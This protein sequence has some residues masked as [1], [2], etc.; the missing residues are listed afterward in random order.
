MLGSIAPKAWLARFRDARRST[1][2]PV[3]QSGASGAGVGGRLVSLPA[4][5]SVDGLRPFASEILR[6]VEACLEHRFDLLGSG[7]VRM[8]HGIVC[9]GRA[10]H[11][12]APAAAV[13]ADREGNWLAGRINRSNLGEAR[14][15][16]TLV[17]PDYVPVDWHLDFISGYRW[18]E[19]VWCRDIRYGRLTG[20]D[21]KIPWELSRMQHLPLLAGAHALARSGHSGFRPPAVYINEFR[22]Q[23]L[24]F[25]AAN[26][27]R[28]GVNWHCPMDVGIRVV[29]ILAAYDLFRG[30][31][32]GWD[33][34]FES[35]LGRSVREHGRFLSGCGGWFGS[36]GNHRLAELVSWLHAA[37]HLGSDAETTRWLGQAVAGIVEEVRRQF[38]PEGTHG[39]GSTTYHALVVEMVV[40]AVDLLDR[41]P[42]DR[43]RGL[44]GLFPLPGWFQERVTRMK[45]FTERV[46]RPDGRLPQIGDND[47]GRFLSKFVSTQLVEGVP[48]QRG[49]VRGDEGRLPSGKGMLNGLTLHGYPDFGL[50]VY[51]SERLYLAM[52]CGGLAGRA[53]YGHFHNDQLSFELCADGI[54]LIVD[55]G[56]YVYTPLPEER[57]RFRSTGMH[58]TLCMDGMEQA[59]WREG[60]RGLFGLRRVGRA[61][62]MVAEEER[63]TG[64]YRYPGGNLAHHREVSFGEQGIWVSDRGPRGTPKSVR[65]SLAPGTQARALAS[66]PGVVLSAAGVE[67]Y[68]TGGPGR[69]SV[70]ESG[71]SPG[72]G[73]IEPS[74]QI[75]LAFDGDGAVWSIAFQ[76]KE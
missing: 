59:H 2:L 44:R 43:Q 60:P 13:R 5:V 38:S 35:V 46:R 58:N 29:N 39:E 55:P 36:R 37:A 28:Y 24:D 11:R 52:R 74:K 34:A 12:Y 7:E 64:E 4:P 31:G 73:R 66:D 70:H 18:A 23:L 17:D 20:G 48:V 32:A 45:G 16:W 50:Y 61:R 14:R 65:W 53:S 27:P 51:R 19:D 63:F 22:N 41:L 76:R 56:T 3:R 42:E 30:D 6:R 26:P 25:T 10:G 33:E 21:V 15:I 47:S 57:N 49:P 75:R 72:Y 1:Y 68:L 9:T 69:W 54:P 40:S 62:V 8:R 67:L 71:Y